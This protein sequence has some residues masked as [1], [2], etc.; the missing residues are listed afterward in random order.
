MGAK[1]Q[2]KKEEHPVEVIARLRQ[3]TQNNDIAI[4]LA[5]NKGV[6]IKSES[7]QYRDF[8]LDGISW[9]DEA[10]QTF[11]EKYI[12]TRV[13][14]VKSGG[15]CTAILYGATGSGKS[16]TMFGDMKEGGIAYKALHHIM[17]DGD[18]EEE[19]V[20]VS[21]VEIYNEEVC[22]LLAR[23]SAKGGASPKRAK[24]EVRGGKVKNSC[25]ISG[26]KADDIVRDIQLVEKKRVVKST[27]CNERSSRSHCIITVYVPAVRGQLV[28]VDMAGSENID[29]AA[30]GIEAKMQTG[31]INQGN[32]ALK[33]VV[34]A[35]ANG[36]NY[37][38]YRD[39]KL[40]MLLQDS[41]EDDKAKILMI[42]CASTDPKDIYKTIGTLEYGSKAKCIAKLPKSPVKEKFKAIDQVILQNRINAMHDSIEKL[43]AENRSKDEF[44]EE[45]EKEL[46]VKNQ[47]VENLKSRVAHI[48]GEKHQIM[49]YMEKIDKKLLKWI[50]KIENNR[51]IITKTEIKTYTDMQEQQAKISEFINRVQSM[52]DEIKCKIN[53]HRHR[54]GLSIE[55]NRVQ[56]PYNL[57]AKSCTISNCLTID[58]TGADI[59][60]I[61]RNADATLGT[62]HELQVQVESA[63]SKDPNIACNEDS[64]ALSCNVFRKMSDLSSCHIEGSCSVT[65]PSEDQ[66]ASEKIRQK[67]EG[68]KR[69][70]LRDWDEEVQFT[71][72]C[73]DSEHQAFICR[74]CDQIDELSSLSDIEIEV[75][76]PSAQVCS[77]ADLHILKENNDGMMH[78]AFSSEVFHQSHEADVKTDMH[79]CDE[80]KTFSEQNPDQSSM[81]TDVSMNSTWVQNPA[82]NKILEV[83]WTSGISFTG[84][85]PAIPETS[86]E[87][88]EDDETYNE[89]SKQDDEKSRW[90]IE[91][92]ENKI[93]EIESTADRSK[94]EASDSNV[95]ADGFGTDPGNTVVYLPNVEEFCELAQYSET[96]NASTSDCPYMRKEDVGD[97]DCK[98]LQMEINRNDGENGSQEAI[99]FSGQID[100]GKM[101]HTETENPFGN[102]LLGTVCQTYTFVE[103]EQGE[104]RATTVNLD[105]A[106]GE[107]TYTGLPQSGPK[108]HFSNDD[109]LCYFE[110]GVNF[111]PGADVHTGTKQHPRY[112]HEE[113]E[114]LELADSPTSLSEEIEV[115]E[116]ADSPTS[117][118]EETE[119]VELVDSLTSLSESPGMTDLPLSQPG[120]SHTSNVDDAS[121]VDVYVKWG[122]STEELDKIICIVSLP[123]VATLAKLRKEITPHIAHANKHFTFLMLGESGGEVDQ[124]IESDLRV[125]SLPDCLFS[126]GCRLACL[127]PPRRIKL[128]LP[129][130][131]LS[132]PLT[133]IE[134]KIPNATQTVDKKKGSKSSNAPIGPSRYKGGLRTMP[135]KKDRSK[136]TFKDKAK[137]LYFQDLARNIL[138]GK[139]GQPRP[140]TEETREIMLKSYNQATE[141]TLQWSGRACKR[142]NDPVQE[143]IQEMALSNEPMLQIQQIGC[144]QA[145]KWNSRVGEGE[146]SVKEA[147]GSKKRNDEGSK[148]SGSEMI[149]NEPQKLAKYRD[150]AD[151][152]KCP[153]DALPKIES[154]RA[155]SN[156]C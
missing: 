2:W 120:E 67:E 7:G 93:L 60:L 39:S 151:A 109:P 94:S 14:G 5:D 90:G 132:V 85:L 122:K 156:K 68:T 66:Q 123:K 21:V 64:Q 88:K 18:G 82:A 35:I 110:L 27:S 20:K 78:P 9:S 74:S 135:N 28:L 89:G 118:S 139:I 65:R 111:D 113:I 46:N 6:R 86:F 8:S 155:D 22:D 19:I 40:T 140:R 130:D 4:Q 53:E 115:V 124:E 55:S 12:K 71:V 69:H 77:S 62:S 17:D 129:P 38:P 91:N 96:S 142:S 15:K 153:N 133:Q 101:L 117:F 47:Q 81:F 116:L 147:R 24:L 131:R 61:S 106:N 59:P 95:M 146:N 128:S 114:V 75:P 13:E 83:D 107:T 37:I 43:Q 51:K 57:M 56:N 126:K 84:W 10:L 119:V 23:S 87:G 152:A 99:Q 98:L 125:G 1:I 144:R 26:K 105:G 102:S 42:L 134:N 137:A 148:S 150:S 54:D 79:M 41:F 76:G 112:N 45:I 58:A 97:E 44:R 92:I 63:I 25:L 50:Q 121:N 141:G 36:D 3:N 104:N 138:H 127:R 73:N 31:K 145:L 136:M 52:E 34:E 11:Y 30:S 143:E 49:M 103:K 33:R 16:Y 100:Y 70:S 72:V 29:Q 48:E 149:Q 154:K 32:G 108:P 80:T